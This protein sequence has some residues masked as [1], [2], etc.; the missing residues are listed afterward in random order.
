MASRKLDMCS[1]PLL[2]K[3]II[4]T[5]PIIL[6]GMLQLLFN[7]ADLIV[8]GNFRGNNSVA[9]VGATGAI[10]NL[11]VNLFIGLSVGVSVVIAHGIGTGN[12]KDVS[13]A[14]HTAVPTAIATGI[15]LTI[16]GVLCSEFFLELMGTPKD[17]IKLSASYMKI[18]FLGV[19][20]NMVYNFGSAIL[21]AAG[22]TVTPLIY[23]IVSGVLNVILN[24][25]FVAVL[26]M[27]VEGV[28]LAT[29]VSQLLSAV[30]VMISL[31]KR[32]DACRFSFKKIKFHSRQLKKIIFIGLPAGIQG[33]LFSISNVLIQSSVNSFGSVVM[34]GNAASQNIEG[35]VYISMNSF[36]QTALNF[37]GQNYGAG[38]FDRIKKILGIDLV[39]VFAVGTILSMLVLFFGQPLLSFYINDSDQAIEYGLIRMKYILITYF[40]CGIMDVMTGML[41]GIG[42]S[43][44]PMLITILGV[45]G[46]RIAWI[47]TVFQSPEY[48]TIESIYLSYPISWAITFAVELT[49][50]LLLLKKKKRHLLSLT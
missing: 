36:Q 32:T 46:I 12:D 15:I 34:S 5:I 39:C 33:S 20:A 47:Y 45:C 50:F 14:V 26:S 29:A 2:K 3:M 48:H 49:M 38:K 21:R 42:S 8:V 6:T 4:Y 18:Y 41:R 16:T 9:A 1:G 35:F 40:L 22:D 31:M 43:A 25:F 37:T 10:I 11:L 23:L 44:A 27:N 24:L 17:V 13:N 30:L 19:T 7:A 28:A